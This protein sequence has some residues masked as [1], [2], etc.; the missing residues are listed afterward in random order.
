MLRDCNY[1][2]NATRRNDM[3]FILIINCSELIR[4]VCICSP[5]LAETSIISLLYAVIA[6]KLSG[7]VSNTLRRLIFVFSFLQNTKMHFSLFCCRVRMYL[8]RCTVLFSP[9]GIRKK[10]SNCSTV[11]WCFPTSGVFDGLANTCRF[12]ARSMFH[13]IPTLREILSSF[14]KWFR[15]TRHD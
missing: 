11:W 14:W 9:R 15:S 3:F 7:Y 4:A 1:P 10:E 6:I 2:R 5:I 13:N 8:F 12:A